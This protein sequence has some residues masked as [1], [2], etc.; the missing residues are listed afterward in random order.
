MGARNIQNRLELTFKNLSNKRTRI[1]ESARVF[2]LEHGLDPQEIDHV[3]EVVKDVFKHNKDKEGLWL[4]FVVV[5]TEIGYQFSGNEYWQSFEKYFPG[6]SNPSNRHW[7]KGAFEKFQKNFNGP[8]PSGIWAS[9]FKVIAYPMTNAII[10]L[11]LQ[12]QFLSV[13]YKLRLV[14]QERHFLDPE[15][16][17]KTIEAQ[18]PPYGSARFKNFLQNRNMIWQLASML[19]N[20]NFGE[21]KELLSTSTLERIV[22]DLEKE[23]HL[24]E[25]LKDTRRQV[26]KLIFKGAKSS[27][28]PNKFWRAKI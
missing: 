17:A 10:P 6:G 22:N 16:L 27:I 23:K 5:S 24:K 26:Q 25:Y 1:N 2:A 11:D 8:I 9:H 14:L 3:F 12:W 15:L 19:L 13:L 4:L 21:N 28:K 18:H 7:L 20:E